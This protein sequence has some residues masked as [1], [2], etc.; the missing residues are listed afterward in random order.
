M[1]YVSGMH[2][3]NI[4]S[5]PDQETDPGIFF[6]FLLLHS[7]Q[8]RVFFNIYIDFSENKSWIFKKCLGKNV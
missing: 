7:L 4:G 2:P 5:G 1:L 3:F 8:E 6:Y